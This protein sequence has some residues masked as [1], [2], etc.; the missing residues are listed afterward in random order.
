[1]LIETDRL[2]LRPWRE[3]DVSGVK[4]VY[5]DPEVRR[6]TGGALASEKMADYVQRLIEADA[7]GDLRLLPLVEKNTGAIVGSCGLQ[8]LEGGPEVEIGWMLARDA[9]GNGYA[10]EM[11]LAVLRY[12]LDELGLGRIYATIDQRN[13]R[14]V[15]VVNRLGMWFEKVARIYKRDMLLYSATRGTWKMRVRSLNAA[16]TSGR[17]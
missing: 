8:P 17:P 3:E 16:G 6:F 5:C 15:A 9:W 14:S 12:G 13:A 11:S 10:T 1:M 4:A 2:L 7:R